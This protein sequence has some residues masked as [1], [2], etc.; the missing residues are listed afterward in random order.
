MQSPAEAQGEA[1][2]EIEQR[3]AGVGAT[4][5]PPTSRRPPRPSARPR[6]PRAESSTR[7]S[8]KEPGRSYKRGQRG[9]FHYEGKLAKD[10]TVFDSSRTNEPTAEL[11]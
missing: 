2:P 11:S 10:D 1:V 4:V 8:R 5:A 7:P 9:T 3:V 6:R